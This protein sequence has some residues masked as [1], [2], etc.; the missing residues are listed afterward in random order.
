MCTRQSGE[1]ES[2]GRKGGCAIKSALCRELSSTYATF[3]VCARDDEEG[4]EGAL[5]GFP[6]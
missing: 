3:P 5:Q 4:E 1:S 2:E 6:D